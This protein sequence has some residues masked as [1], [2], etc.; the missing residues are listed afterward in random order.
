MAEQSRAK[1]VDAAGSRTMVLDFTVSS[2]G[3]TKRLNITKTCFVLLN[4]FHLPCT[5]GSAYIHKLI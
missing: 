2:A 4:N 3:A 5:A 1:C